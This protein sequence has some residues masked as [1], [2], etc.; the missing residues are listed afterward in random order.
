MMSE[1]L[2]SLKATLDLWRKTLAEIRRIESEATELEELKRQLRSLDR[3]ILRTLE[4]LDVASRGNIGWE[5]RVI[6]FLAELEA[7]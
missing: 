2:S 4:D 6:A 5:H 1:R 7:R 3:E